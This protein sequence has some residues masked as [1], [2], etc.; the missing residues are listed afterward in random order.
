MTLALKLRLSAKERP[1][2][3]S[4]YKELTMFDVHPKM[5]NILKSYYKYAQIATA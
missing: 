2:E 1:E 3:T 4:M 5:K